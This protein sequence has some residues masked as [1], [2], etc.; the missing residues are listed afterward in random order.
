MQVCLQN[1]ISPLFGT[2]WFSCY[3]PTIELIAFKVMIVYTAL[4]L[5]MAGLAY[6]KT[7]GC[8]ERLKYLFVILTFVA[9]V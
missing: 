8:K 2:S 3:L 4:F 6:V 7:N 5:G 9:N 1:I